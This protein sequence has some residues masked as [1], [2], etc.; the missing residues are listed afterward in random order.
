MNQLNIT[1][2]SLNKDDRLNNASYG[3][4]IPT[5]SAKLNK[6]ELIKFDKYDVGVTL[7]WMIF[8]ESFNEYQFRKFNK[9]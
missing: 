5:I 4:A 7:D 2:F 1:M 8:S 3:L 9:E 6:I